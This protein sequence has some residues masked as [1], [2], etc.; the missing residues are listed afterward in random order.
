MLIGEQPECVEEE[1]NM[2]LLLCRVGARAIVEFLFND[3]ILFSE[4]FKDSNLKNLC[5]KLNSV[6]NFDLTKLELVQK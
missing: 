4:I 5:C 6:D 2:F 3:K 1:F